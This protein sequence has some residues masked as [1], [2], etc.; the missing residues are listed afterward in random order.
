MYL[1][2]FADVSLAD[3]PGQG[4]I[5][6][7]LTAFDLD[8]EVIGEARFRTDAAIKGFI[9]IVGPPDR[10]IRRIDISSTENFAF[11]NLWHPGASLSPVELEACPEPSAAAL[12]LAA[13]VALAI[14]SARR[15]P[16]ASRRG[17]GGG[18]GT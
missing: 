17:Y 13:V 14:L 5:E 1:S 4:G 3:D 11:D 2:S 16:A 18:G 7:T 12:G 8:G 9:G 15:R 10:S 6:V